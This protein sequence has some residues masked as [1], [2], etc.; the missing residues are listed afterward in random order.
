MTPDSERRARVMLSFLA[1]PGDA[2][3]GAALRARSA[4]EILALTTGAGEAADV[5]NS[6][7][8]AMPGRWCCGSAAPRT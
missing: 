2:V 8:S 3:L 4:A 5:H 6:T 1:D 7:T